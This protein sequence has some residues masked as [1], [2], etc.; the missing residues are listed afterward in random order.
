M[1]SKARISLRVHPWCGEEV[2]VVSRVGDE[3]VL[4]EHADGFRRVIPLSWTELVPVIEA[5]SVAGHEAKLTPR[6]AHVLALWV[7]ARVERASKQS[8]KS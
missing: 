2:A 3:S 1:C 7:A 5:A 6:V 8:R 4:V